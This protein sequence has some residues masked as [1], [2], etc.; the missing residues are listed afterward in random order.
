MALTA[1]PMIVG[2]TLSGVVFMQISPWQ[3]FQNLCARYSPYSIQCQQQQQQLQ[4][5][6][7]IQPLQP[8]QPLQPIQ[9]LAPQQDLPGDGN[10]SP[11]DSG[12]GGVVP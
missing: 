8:V 5:L 1:L 3:L 10:G 12:S 6:E 4:P 7:P 9:P 2:I 11:L